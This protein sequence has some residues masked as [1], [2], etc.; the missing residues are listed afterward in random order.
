MS[1]NHT[2]TS[3]EEVLDI[4]DLLS[5]AG[6]IRVRNM[7]GGYLVYLDEV[8]IGQINEKRLHIKITPA[9]EKYA[10]RMKQVSPY[11]GAKLAY[12]VANKDI[13]A[14]W[15]IELIAATRDEL[16]R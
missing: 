1:D 4:V 8:L 13:G 16:K 12:E 15:L 14:D 10:S 2:K 7:M 5:P 11:P 3:K 9:G 6:T